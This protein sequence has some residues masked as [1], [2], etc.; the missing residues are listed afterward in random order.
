MRRVLL[1][2]ALVLSARLAQ[3]QP[4]LLT[5]HTAGGPNVVLRDVRI[6]AIYSEINGFTARAEAFLPPAENPVWMHLSLQMELLLEDGRRR[7]LAMQC[8]SCGERI[9]AYFESSP[10]EAG[11]VK[12]FAVTI[13]S[14]DYIAEKELPAYTGWVARDAGCYSR[15][16]AHRQPLENL[17]AAGCVERTRSELAVAIESNGRDVPDGALLVALTS[18]PGEPAETHFGLVPKRLV[19]MKRVRVLQHVDSTP[20]ITP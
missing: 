4:D 14:G 5:V 3:A 17:V 6:G 12:Q 8:S 15:A 19:R 20:Q 16:E 2:A 7:E 18:G 1:L 9:V 10:W 13:F 11:H